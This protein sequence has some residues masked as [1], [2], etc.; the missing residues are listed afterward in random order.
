[1]YCDREIK[2]SSDTILAFERE[3]YMIQRETN[4][5]LSRLTSIHQSAPHI[6]FQYP[7]SFIEG[8]SQVEVV[9]N[10]K[11]QPSAT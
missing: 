4:G 3:T 11:N 5:C 2:N 7:G 1:M 10:R 9:A 8:D 6:V